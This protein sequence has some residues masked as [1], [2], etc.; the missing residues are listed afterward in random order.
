M[1][2][3][4]ASKTSLI[5]FVVAL[6]AAMMTSCGSVTSTSDGGTAGASGSS[7][8]G[9]GGTTGSAGSSGS[10]G[11]GGTTGV[12][13]TTGAAGRGGAGG[14]NAGTGGGSGGN[15]GTGGRG[16]LGGLDGGVLSCRVD[17]SGDCP[18]GF[19]CAC[20]GAGPVGQCTCHR[21]CTDTS[22]CPATEPMCGCPGSTG[23]ARY[24]VNL[25]FCECD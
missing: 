3:G 11:T 9:A 17:M 14:G 24:C 16:G 18:T 21:N 25:C 23:A 22:A 19:T 20:G 15:A 6:G 13:G 12:A 7:G 2:S 8:G 10:A 1:S 4:L 5:A